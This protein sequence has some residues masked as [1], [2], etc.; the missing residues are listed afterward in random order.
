MSE[1]FAPER[2]VILFRR[3]FMGPRDDQ[4]RSVVPEGPTAGV[5][6][7]IEKVKDEPPK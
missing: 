6:L 3:R 1:Q 5:M 2:P 4:G 7:W